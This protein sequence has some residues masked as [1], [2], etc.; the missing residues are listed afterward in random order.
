V[1]I[2]S[3]VLPEAP[4]VRVDAARV[5]VAVQVP[6]EA[7]A[8]KADGN[9]FLPDCGEDAFDEG[10][11][12][13]DGEEPVA[14]SEGV[15]VLDEGPVV[16]SL[17]EESALLDAPPPDVDEGS[18]EEDFSVH[19]KKVPEKTL[20]LMESYFHARFI[21]YIPPRQAKPTVIEK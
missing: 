12:D 9:E 20:A 16:Q 10:C 4:V 7:I 1:P 21:R 6:V 19:L 5:E 17:E 8:I 13:L 3:T 2:S 15:L 11:G 14:E 18:K